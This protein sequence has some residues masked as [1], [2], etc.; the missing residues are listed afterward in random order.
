MTMEEGADGEGLAPPPRRRTRKR[1]W[2]EDYR[3]FISSEGLVAAGGKDAASNDRV[4]RKY[5]DDLDRYAH[6]DVH[7]ASSVVVKSAGG[8]APGEATMEEACGFA[9]IHSRAWEQGHG[10]GTAYWVLPEQVS[11]TPQAGEALPRGAFIIRGKR[12]WLRD[13]PLLVAV[14]DV[15]HEGVRLVMGAP[16][17]TVERLL[18]RE[19]GKEGERRRY[20]VLAPGPVAKNTAA[21]LLASAFQVT[22]EEVA[23]VLPSGGVQL[24]DAVGMPGAVVEGFMER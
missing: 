11:K 8:E 21:L 20:V 19:R 17:L 4:V 6:A 5:L 3:W 22:E 12:N 24:V 15:E 16:R 23:G 1:F 7:G 18:E 13:L 2:F 10:G 14:T 9:V